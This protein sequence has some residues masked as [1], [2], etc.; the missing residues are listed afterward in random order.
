M[1]RGFQIPLNEK[2]LVF[3]GYKPSL[4]QP[5]QPHLL[6]RGLILRPFPL[7]MSAGNLLCPFCQVHRRT[8]IICRVSKWI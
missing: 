3:I 4:S 5:E 2:V 7:Q 6:L 8:G 1:E